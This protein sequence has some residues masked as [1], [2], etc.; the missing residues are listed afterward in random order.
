M[1]FSFPAGGGYRSLG[2][3]DGLVFMAGAILATE[4]RY[5]WLE[6]EKKGVSGTAWEAVLG[7]NI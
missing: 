2:Y 4:G 6:R 5:G 1:I 7:G 3:G